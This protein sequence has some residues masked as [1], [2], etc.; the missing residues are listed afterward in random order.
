MKE[1]RVVLDAVGPLLSEH[2]FKKRAGDVFTLELTKNVLGWLG[3]NRA[4]QHRP[5]GEVEIN[6]VVGIRHQEV[7]RLVSELRGEKFHA[8]Q[9]PTISC[10]LGYL[11]PEQRY[12]AWIFP[13]GT[14]GETAADMAA[15]IASYGV[16]FMRSAIELTDLCRLLDRDL[17]FEHQLVYRRPVAW[18]LAGDPAQAGR[19]L[20]ISLAG[21]G[22]RDDL[23]AA[24]FRRFAAALRARLYLPK[25]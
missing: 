6:P 22:S 19:S 1:A 14:A 11:L 23:A 17:G 18:L 13:P 5:P 10:P 4:T 9:P 15:A 8:Y 2:G 21:L 25:V 24:E 3:L 7:E 12:R 16:P 20:D